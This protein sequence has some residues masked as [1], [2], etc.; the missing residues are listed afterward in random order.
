MRSFPLPE[1]AMKREPVVGW[2]TSP[3]G[4]RKRDAV[5]TPSAEPGMV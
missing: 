1:S 4:V 3:N 2:R 5:P